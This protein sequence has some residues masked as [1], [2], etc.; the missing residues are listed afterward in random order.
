LRF[1]SAYKSAYC[2]IESRD[3]EFFLVPYIFSYDLIKQAKFTNFCK[4]KAI[5]FTLFDLDNVNNILIWEVDFS[6]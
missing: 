5:I 1:V 3:L 4:L 6:I 2:R